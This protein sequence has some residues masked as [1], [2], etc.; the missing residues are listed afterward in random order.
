MLALAG[1]KD[2]A[3]DD[4]G[5]PVAP[6][7]EVIH[8]DTR[9]GVTLEAD[10]YAGDADAPAVL[11]MH[12]T[13]LQF[14][15]TSWPASFITLLHDKGWSVLVPDRR[16]AGGSEGEPRDAFE[17]EYGRYDVEAGVSH[18]T[19]YTSGDFIIIAGS[20][21]TT[22]TLDYSVWA[23]GEGLPMP[24]ALG[25]M[26]GGTYTETQSSMSDLPELPVVFTYS[27]QER[28]WS[29]AQQGL[30]NGPDWVF[31]EYP[32][33]AHGTRMFDAAPEV[34]TDLESFFDGVLE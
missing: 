12:M 25:L 28:A 20:N 27:T 5:G 30:P 18:L 26:T 14:D 2:E 33:G 16:G 13:P 19:G 17:G 29:V 7:G 22:A 4:S 32:D 6:G 8:F 31:L 24:V 21:G 3:V 1:C 11:L 34:A 23:T 15:R 9:D 10:W